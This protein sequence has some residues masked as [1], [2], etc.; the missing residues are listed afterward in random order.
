MKAVILA[1]G[2]GTR[3]SEET[4]IKPK[5]LVEI[6]GKPILWHIIKYLNHYGIKHFYV[7][8]GYKGYLIK[9]YFFNYALHNSN[10]TI[11]TKN[12]HCKFLKKNK[13]D[14]KI[15][16]I[17]TG[18]NTMTGGRLLR[19]KEFLKNEKEFIF[20]YGD[21]LSDINIKELIKFH[22]SHK[23]IATI[24]SVA[25]PGRFGS[26]ILGKKNN[27]II[28]FDEKPIG[29]GQKIN[30]G[31]FVLK[32]KVFKYLKDDS[33]VWEE[34]PIKNLVKDGELYAFKHNGFWQP[35]DTLREKKYLNI[36]WNNGKAS[37]KVWK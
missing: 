28:K 22:K 25:P 12:G 14:W 20:T 10:I 9:E 27:K 23:K 5:P 34:D 30:G 13:E 4:E 8:C 7:C 24:T 32:S 2:F 16:L 1:G 33:S 11:D 36:L 35:M 26:I 37:W 15:S 29:D 19:L 21:G 18:D 17:D 3:L 6:G 31:Y